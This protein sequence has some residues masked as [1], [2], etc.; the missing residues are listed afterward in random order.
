MKHEEFLKHEESHENT[1]H[2]MNEQC[3]AIHNITNFENIHQ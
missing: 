3:V 2:H 1:K